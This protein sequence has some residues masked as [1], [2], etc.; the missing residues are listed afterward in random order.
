MSQPGGAQYVF[1][2]N[3]IYHFKIPTM[4]ML[5]FFQ[6]RLGISLPKIYQKSS[7]AWESDFNCRICELI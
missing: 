3:K 1:Q 4:Q 7:A 5:V 6:T 2:E